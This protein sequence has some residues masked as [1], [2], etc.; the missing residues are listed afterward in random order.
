[1]EARRKPQAFAAA[2]VP[3]HIGNFNGLFLDRAALKFRVRRIQSDSSRLLQQP[4]VYLLRLTPY[5]GLKTTRQPMLQR[6]RRLRLRSYRRSF[7]TGIWR[8]PGGMVTELLTTR[9]EHGVEVQTRIIVVASGR[10]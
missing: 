10:S 3:I 4:P 2:A 5:P 7:P 6:P 1:L 8:G 9:S